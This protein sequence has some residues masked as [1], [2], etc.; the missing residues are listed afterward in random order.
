[1]LRYAGRCWI[2]EA[3]NR[4]Q[5]GFAA[6][7]AGASPDIENVADCGHADAMTFFFERWKCQPL[8]GADVIGFN[9]IVRIGL[10]RF[11]PGHNNQISQSA[12]ADAAA[13]RWQIVLSW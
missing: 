1:L 3:L 11:S 12:C 5:Y 2:R 9:F 13:G 6:L 10:G 7:I 8:P 4:V